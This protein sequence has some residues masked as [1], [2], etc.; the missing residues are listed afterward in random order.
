MITVITNLSILPFSKGGLRG[1]SKGFKGRISLENL[2]I[3]VIIFKDKEE[4][5]EVS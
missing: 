5:W 3:L 1:I 4:K 2:E